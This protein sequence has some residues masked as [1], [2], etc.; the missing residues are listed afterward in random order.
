[1]TNEVLAEMQKAALAIGH[2]EWG[3]THDL[4]AKGHAGH[5]ERSVEIT[6]QTFDQ[7]GPQKMHGLYVKGSETVIGHTG[8]S[9]NSPTHA[10]ILTALWNKFVDEALSSKEPKA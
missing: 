2:V 10:R 5:V 1:M 8:T 7:T 9:P 6:A 3:S 4:D